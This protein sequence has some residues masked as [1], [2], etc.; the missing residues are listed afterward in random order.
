M[1]V[2]IYEEKENPSTDYF[3]HPLLYFK[4][5][6]FKRLDTKM[7]LEDNTI[8]III[9]YL[10]HE[11]LRFIKKNFNNISNII[12]FMDDDLWD[13]KVLYNI[14]F[15]YAIKIYRNALSYKNILIKLGAKLMVSNE[16]LANKYS[17]YK[18]EIIY[19]YP[20]KLNNHSDYKICE[21]NSIVTYHATASHRKEFYWISEILPH[22]PD[23]I[24]EIITDMKC[25][26]LFKNL[27][28]CWL[29]H[30]M[31]WSMYKKFI[32]TQRRA[33]AIAFQLNNDFNIARSY[34]KFF[35]ILQ[36]GAVGFYSQTFP[37]ARLIENFNAGIVVDLN[38]E[39]WIKTL[40]ELISYD[41]RKILYKN[42]LSL[43]EFFKKRAIQS[44]DNVN[45][46]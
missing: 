38:K 2:L 4:N 43:L 5:Y 44:Y 45:F 34:V 27:N 30:Q 20:L 39:S 32:S 14:P 37:E 31:S 46:S 19:P 13:Y 21:S 7:S 8:I 22:I 10:S 28:N 1:K 24:F 9:R 26:K 42:S 33:Y 41:D 35:N 15:K 12:Y 40:K 23:K 25:F 29:I 16:Y 36:L 3:I 17:K 18:P 6:E 11:L